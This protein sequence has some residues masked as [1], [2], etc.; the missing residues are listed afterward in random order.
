MKNFIKLI[1]TLTLLIIQVIGQAQNSLG[2]TDDIQRIA[3]S[4]YV[5]DQIENLP[6][7]AE[8]TLK[9]KMSQI[10]SYDGLGGSNFN[11][12]FIITP[13]INVLSKNITPTAPV[14]TALVLDVTLYIG[15]GFS[16]AKYQSVSLQVKGVGINEAKAYL[17]ALKQIKPNDKIIQDFVNSGKRKI[18]EYYNDNCDFIIKEAQTYASQNN[19]EAAIQTLTSVPPVCKECYNKCNDAVAPIYQKSIDRECKLLLTEAKN[20]WNSGLDIDAANLAST[21]LNQID[22]YSN[23]YKEANDLTNKIGQRVKELDGREWK[24]ILKKQQ[25]EVNILSAKN[26]AARAIG[27]AYGN[28]QPANSYNIRGWW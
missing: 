9:N 20:A 12:R 2:K 3:L 11:Q 28:N 26:S 1:S 5:S 17:A 23:C 7:I 24:F 25:D 6:A 8:S 13:N 18:I 14:M 27:V 16:G 19:F 22:P 10:A 4:S 21:Y 15:D